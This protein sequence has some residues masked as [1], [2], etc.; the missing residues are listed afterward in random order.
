MLPVN[1]QPT[2]LPLRRQPA[3]VR[4]WLSRVLS[5]MGYQMLS[6]AVGWQMYDLTRNPLDLGLLGL[7]QFL[8]AVG[9]VLVVGQVADRFDRRVVARTTL[10]VQFL[11][12]LGLAVA[13]FTSQVSP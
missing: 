6:V 4:Y 2:L 5:G 8:P 9:L 7:A 12:T 1:K 3:L 11:L 10:T 13:S